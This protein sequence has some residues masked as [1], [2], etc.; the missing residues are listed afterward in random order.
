MRNFIGL[1]RAVIGILVVALG[2]MLLLDSTNFLQTDTRFF[3]TY[4]PSLLIVWGLWGFIANGFRLRLGYTAILV[5]GICFQL[6]QLE[7]WSWDA[8][9]LWPV[10]VVVAGLF[11]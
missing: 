6:I 7:L 3:N 8:S 10:L 9:Q 2:V 5:V 11:L 4:W 1:D